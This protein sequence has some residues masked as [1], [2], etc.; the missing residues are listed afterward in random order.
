MSDF[1]L[2]L[3]DREAVGIFFSWGRPRE[4]VGIFFLETGPVKMLDFVYF[5]V[6][7]AGFG[8]FWL[9]EGEAIGEAMGISFSGA[10][11]SEA[12]GFFFLFLADREA[13]GFFSGGRPRR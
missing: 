5:L 7:L 6:F 4:A 1:F 12:V 11:L 3:A 8:Y 10:Q 13:V 9:D 2:F